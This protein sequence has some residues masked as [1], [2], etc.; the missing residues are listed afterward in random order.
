MPNKYIIK[1]VFF[2]LFNICFL[3][4]N[5]QLNAF[6]EDWEPRTFNN[7]TNIDLQP[8]VNSSSDVVINI[9]TSNVIADVLPS[10][11][12][13]NMTHFLGQSVI[14]DNDF[15]SNLKNLGKTIL[16]YPGGNG[17]NQFFWDGNIPSSILNDSQIT[18]NNLIDGSGWRISPDEFV[19]ILDST[20]GSGIIAVNAS[21][22]RYGT[23]S[24]PIQTAASYAASFVRH[25]NQ[26]L[27]ANIKYWE[28]GNENYGPWQA[29]YLV[30]GDTIDG[31]KYGDIFNV[32]ADSMKTADP[33]IKIGAVLYRHDGV[34][35]DW[36]KKVLSKVEN[37]ADFLIIHN[38]F[39]RKPNPNN[40]TYQEML[41]SLGQVQQDVNRVKNMVASYTNKPSDYFP[42]AIT[43]FNSKTGEREISMAN[44]IFITQALGE[45][46]KNGFAASILWSF[47]NGLD[48]HGGDHGMT[49]RNSTIL[50]DH[51]PR[52]VFYIYHFFQKFM[53]DRLIWSYSSDTAVKSYA[54]TFSSD[55]R[56]I[57][58]V[59]NSS[60]FKTVD[61]D[62][63]SDTMR[64]NYYWYEVYANNET[65]KKIF[66]NG[67]TSNFNEGGPENYAS[68]PPFYRP[69]NGNNKFEL[70]PYSVNFIANTDYLLG[71]ENLENDID[72]I[73]YPN[74]FD[75]FININQQ[76]DY[77]KLFDLSGNLV[78]K[79]SKKYLDTKFLNE[80]IYILKLYG[81]NTSSQFKVLKIKK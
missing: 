66:I 25:M 57:I 11:F 61:L 6:F 8:E 37:K 71:Q 44:A 54:S 38:Y 63:G 28:V 32:F 76:Y 70:K 52:P 4:F 58:L 2:L 29:G 22:A 14:N 13:T 21:Y 20:S 78:L 51:Y 36:S 27:N 56:G 68:I 33:L 24:N 50:P 53:G 10:H 17:S 80:G 19:Q 72:L 7:F 64:Y 47:Q 74:P 59:N 46:I 81:S 42:I 79:S 34:Y 77:L 48:S 55:T 60:N 69:V 5:S 23:S 49:A 65:D 1:S 3:V 31:I 67:Q 35:N 30:N 9:N 43:E 73:I 75:E 40:V 26:T 45:Q 18:I 62:L 15:M 39:R 12:G 41:T 16:R